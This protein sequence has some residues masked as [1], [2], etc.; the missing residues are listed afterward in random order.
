MP[1]RESDPTPTPQHEPRPL[2]VAFVTRFRLPCPNRVDP[3]PLGS[4]YSY[5]LEQNS[6]CGAPSPR[7]GLPRLETRV[8]GPTQNKAAREP[9]FVSARRILTL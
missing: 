1:E 2:A 5:I 4:Y 6:M 9:P 3:S 8:D 7:G